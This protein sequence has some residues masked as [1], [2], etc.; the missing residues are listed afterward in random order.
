MR[1]TQPDSNKLG[2]IIFDKNGN[3]LYHR[4]DFFGGPYVELRGL[5]IEAFI[6]YLMLHWPNHWAVKALKDDVDRDLIRHEIFEDLAQ[7]IELTEE[8]LKELKR[9]AEGSP[10]SEE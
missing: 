6:A 4:L 2:V 1:E 10:E 3:L 9:L 8:D 5:P 7:E